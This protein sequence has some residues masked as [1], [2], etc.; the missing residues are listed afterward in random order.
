MEIK[1][2]EEALGHVPEQTNV[3]RKNDIKPQKH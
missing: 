1:G 2:H 3:G